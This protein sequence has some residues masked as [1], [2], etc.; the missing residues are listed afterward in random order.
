MWYMNILF[1]REI[2]SSSKPMSCK[3]SQFTN[4]LYPLYNFDPCFYTINHVKYPF[5]LA[6]SY[7]KFPSTNTFH[8]GEGSLCHW[9]K[10]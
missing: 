1:L 5:L 7:E 6:Y 2:S 9:E 8:V 4:G 3:F 10:I